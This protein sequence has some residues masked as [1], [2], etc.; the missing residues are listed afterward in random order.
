M[1]YANRDG[2]QLYYEEAGTGPAIIFAHEYGG[3]LHSWE[4]QMRRFSRS[5]RC[6]AFNARG[7]P[8]SDVPEDAAAYGYREASE[9]ICAI[10][11]HVGV[12]QAYVV[13]LSMGAYSAL[14]FTLDHPDRVSG[15]VFA[16]G[17]SGSFA[18][19]RERFIAE[20]KVS[21][22]A[23][24]DDGMTKFATAMAYGPA[25]IQLLNKDPRGWREFSESLAEHSPVGSALTMLYNQAYRPSVFELEDRL[26]DC[27]VPVLLVVGDED[28]PVLETNLFLKRA[29]RASGLVVLPRTGHTVNLEEPDAF[30]HFT[31]DFFAEIERG[32][33]LP[34]DS[35]ALASRSAMLADEHTE[36]SSDAGELTAAASVPANEK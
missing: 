15:L 24:L 14:T 27:Q 33:W 31:Q 28:D 11:D 16:A 3:D 25:R 23:M 29:L 5:Y 22:Q 8:P 30:N 34:R 19:T 20:V 1:P 12:Q 7:F 10:L 17:G 18:A 35:R 2:V 26:R 21:A 13:G 4:P 6:V 32:R 9:D 36:Q